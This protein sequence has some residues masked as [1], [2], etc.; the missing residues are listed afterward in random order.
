MPE[1]KL[2]REATV[3]DDRSIAK[4]PYEKTNVV[5]IAAVRKKRENTKEK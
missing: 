2:P 3:I 4:P 1:P 5:P